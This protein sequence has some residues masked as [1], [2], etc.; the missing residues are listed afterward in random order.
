MRSSQSRIRVARVSKDAARTHRADTVAVEEPLE[1]RVNGEPLAVTMRTPVHDFS[2]AVGFALS[3]GIIHAVDDV[4]SVRYCQKAQQP[5]GL[6]PQ[7]FQSRLGGDHQELAI[8]PGSFMGHS[9]DGAQISDNVV[10]ITLAPHVTPPSA[11]LLRH[12]VVSSSCGLCGRQSL[13]EV[14][15][16]GCY[17][18]DQRADFTLDETTV[19]GLPQVLG[20]QQK[21]F[22]KTG[23]LHGVGLYDVDTGSMVL[24]REDVGRH[25]AV[26]KVLGWALLEG[27]LPLQRHVLV[28]SSRASFEILQKAAMAGVAMVVAV[29]APSSLAVELAEQNNMT[30][31]GFTRPHRCVIYAGEQRVVSPA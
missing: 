10:D 12:T 30:L 29:S 19:M 9:H 15:Q 7:H 4:V 18:L 16:K 17:P 2:L 23:G 8:T 31:V 20:E 14:H 6:Y 21:V 13:D 26:D 11:N 27:L 1:I 5:V 24:V 28:T 22:A 3:E 25:N